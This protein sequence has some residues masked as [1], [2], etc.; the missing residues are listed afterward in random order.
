MSD[1]VRQMFASIAGKYDFM[2][3]LL[4]FGIH[5]RWREKAVKLSNIK[6]GMKIL[7]LAT[8]TGD[9]AIEFSKR[10]KVQVIGVDFCEPMIELA[11]RKIEKNFY[12]TPSPIL[13]RS[14][15]IET[16]VNSISNNIYNIS[17]EI[18]DAT[19]LRFEDNSFDISSIAFGIRNVDSPLK[20]L[21]EMARVVKHGGNIVVIEFG[22]P[23]GILS[24]LYKIYS[25]IFMPILGKII[26][27]NFEAY[28]YLPET[29][30][31]FPCREEFISMM[32]QTETLV[33]CSYYSLSGGVAYIY[34][35]DVNKS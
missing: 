4:S 8:G 7:D 25:K 1:T 26:A 12:K 5:K 2:N 20:C 13:V 11:K 23:N 14:N 27:K 34:L 30:S 28:V 33:N 18:G 32:E 16:Q 19:D 31:R 24:I 3:T 15:I 6:D 17:F 22:Q 35:A 29:A 10:S 21:Q 9:F